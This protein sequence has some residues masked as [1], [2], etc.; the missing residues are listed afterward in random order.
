MTTPSD[1]P[2]PIDRSRLQAEI[3]R[4]IGA[5]EPGKS[6]CPS[7]VARAVARPGEDWRAQMKPVRAEAMRLAADGVIAILRHGKPV[8]PEGVRGVIRLARGPRFTS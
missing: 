8:A 1:G 7:E 4:Q 3:L 2:G 6:I 5:R